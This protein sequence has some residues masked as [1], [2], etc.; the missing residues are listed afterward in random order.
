MGKI[1]IKRED[2]ENGHIFYVELTG[3]D[4]LLLNNVLKKINPQDKFGELVEIQN[5]FQQICND[6][7]KYCELDTKPSKKKANEEKIA[8]L[9]QNIELFK[10][11]RGLI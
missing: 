6:L 10:K 3:K 2:I 4:I 9:E 1:A 11:E 5:S 7:A 8:A